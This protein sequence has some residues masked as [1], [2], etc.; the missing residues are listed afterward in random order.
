MLF[1]IHQ[2]QKTE[3][4][5]AAC[6]EMKGSSNRLTSGVVH[7]LK[8]HDKNSNHDKPCML[9]LYFFHRAVHV[10]LMRMRSNSLRHTARGRGI[11]LARCSVHC[12]FSG[13]VAV[14]RSNGGS[15]HWL[16]HHR[17]S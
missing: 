8:E 12:H 14:L 17:F 6:P 7:E 3:E 16:D 1:R 13:A 9:P 10:M 4:H 11:V 2:Q 5:H 15:G